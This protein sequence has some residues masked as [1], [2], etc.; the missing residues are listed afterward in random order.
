MWVCYLASHCEGT[1]DMENIL[2]L[3]AEENILMLETE[4]NRNMEK[5]TVTSFII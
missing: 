1:T 2:K 3:S 5:G 4:S